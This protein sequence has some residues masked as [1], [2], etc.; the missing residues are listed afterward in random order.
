MLGCGSPWPTFQGQKSQKGGDQNI[1]ELLRVSCLYSFC[2]SCH[3]V[4]KKNMPQKDMLHT[5]YMALLTVSVAW[6]TCPAFTWNLIIID[7]KKRS[8]Q[9]HSGPAMYSLISSTDLVYFLL[10]EEATVK[11]FIRNI[12]SGSLNFLDTLLLLLLCCQSTWPWPLRKVIVDLI[13][14]SA[15]ISEEESTILSRVLS[16]LL[17][18]IS[19]SDNGLGQTL[20]IALSISEVHATVITLFCCISMNEQTN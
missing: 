1:N 8:K 19:L 4:L 2:M 5:M 13:F 7:H 3:L 15:V 6:R 9:P 18:R 16:A 10:N 12:V 20:S 14:P 17:V 11:H